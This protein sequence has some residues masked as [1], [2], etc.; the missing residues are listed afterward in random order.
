LRISCV[1][2]ALLFCS[3]AASASDWHTLEE[4]E[5][6]TIQI[7]RDSIVPAGG[8]LKKAWIMVS[9]VENQSTTGYPV[10]IYKSTMQLSL[11]NC[12]ERTMDSLQEILYSDEFRGGKIVRS[13]AYP[14]QSLRLV[15]V[16][17]GSVGEDWLN[18]AC[19]WK[20]KKK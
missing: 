1:A 10:L 15:D 2:I 14:R 13:E 12:E 7:D 19:R 4:T 16:V 11:L 18:Y 9:H 17:P 5:K 3:T 20:T 8:G 6:N